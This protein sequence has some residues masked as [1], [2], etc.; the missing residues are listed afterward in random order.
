MRVPTVFM[1]ALML[2]MPAIPAFAQSAEPP[3]ITIRDGPVGADSE[4]RMVLLKTAT[5]TCGDQTPATPTYSEDLTPE[6][7]SSSNRQSRFGDIVLSFSI[8]ADGR[9]RDIRPEQGAEAP[10]PISFAGYDQGEDQATLAAW[11]FPP[12]ALKDC[13]LT[14]A[15][16]YMPIAYAPPPAVALLAVSAG[17]RIGRSAIKTLFERRG[18]D[19]ASPP[20]LL[21]A[22]YPDRRKGSTPPGGRS[23]AMIR[24]DILADGSTANIE[25]IASSGDRVFEAESRRA[26]GETRFVDADARTGCA[27]P[28]SRTGADLTDIP[29]PEPV[30]DVLK[31]CPAA[32][33][34]RFTPGRLT[35]PEAFRRRGIE[36]WAIVRYD[37]ASWGQVGAVSVLEAQPAAAFGTAA[38][39][40]IAS[41]HA[42]PGF[43]GAVR[44]TDRVIFHMP[45][46]GETPNAD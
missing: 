40:A 9:T 6:I 13:R 33:R 16:H 37:I 35:Y 4:S 44:C 15:R 8:D 29:G 18:D 14:I 26:V 31:D 22:S 10:S 39:Q 3:I 32:V 2:A 28:F 25:T 1:I 43:T 11:R 45:R 21:T 17:G 34:A 20:A 42:T 7:L 30:G 19:C 36:G 5:A 41:G 24:W 27:A 12:T 38:R 46:D 23:W